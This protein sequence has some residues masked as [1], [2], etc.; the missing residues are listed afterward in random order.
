MA[1]RVLNQFDYSISNINSLE[2]LHDRLEWWRIMPE[3][4]YPKMPT[5]DFHFDVFE[6]ASF[7]EINAFAI[8]LRDCESA[9]IIT[10]VGVP[11][12]NSQQGLLLILSY[13]SERSFD[14]SL[15]FYVKSDA[16]HPQFLLPVDNML[17]LVSNPALRK[18]VFNTK[19]PVFT[20]APCPLLD[21]LNELVCSPG[22]TIFDTVRDNFV[23]NEIRGSGLAIL[24]VTWSNAFE[25]L[26]LFAGISCLRDI[27]ILRDD[28][29]IFKHGLY[30]LYELSIALVSKSRIDVFAAASVRALRPYIIKF[31]ANMPLKR[32]R[33]KDWLVPDFA[34]E[35]LLH[36]IAGHPTLR[37]VE[38]LC[39]DIN[40][41][42][43]VD[44]MECALSCRNHM[45]YFIFTFSRP[46]ESRVQL[47]NIMRLEDIE[48]VLK[49]KHSNFRVG[50]YH[51]ATDDCCTI[52]VIEHDLQADE[53]LQTASDYPSRAKHVDTITLANQPEGTTA[54]LLRICVQP[55]YPLKNVDLYNCEISDD[56]LRILSAAN[57][58]KNLDFT[59]C[60]FSSLSSE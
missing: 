48:P 7:T 49:E 18:L 50:D 4:N 44:I 34:F 24:E 8:L 19:A 51:F 10:F 54:A 33:L 25:I 5:I 29:F 26:Y 40:P 47:E 15:E 43:K 11:N 37:Y 2:R 30:Y 36:V 28:Q 41:L 32:L 42:L 31:I 12:S 23:P 52:N 16:I 58:M 9:R 6:D 57:N 3:A 56:T 21:T 59:S 27:V 45:E 22:T 14:F 35:T 39:I 38:C 46:F 13:L 53:F 1:R 55:N 17:R 20:L 60:T